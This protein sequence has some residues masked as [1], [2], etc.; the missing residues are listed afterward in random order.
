M[1][2]PEKIKIRYKCLLCN[3]L[4]DE[5]RNPLP[6]DKIEEVIEIRLTYCKPCYEYVEWERNEY[7]F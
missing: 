2:N 5:H 1:N 6:D 7:N 4:L 3:R